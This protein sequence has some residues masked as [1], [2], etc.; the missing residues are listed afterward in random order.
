MC[1]IRRLCA[2]ALFIIFCSGVGGCIAHP[3][4]LTDGTYEEEVRTICGMF[5]GALAGL[6]AGVAVDLHFD[7]RNRLK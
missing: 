1:G 4:A 7:L 3:S 5:F 2:L 6:A